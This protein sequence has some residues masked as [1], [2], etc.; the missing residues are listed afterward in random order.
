MTPAPGRVRLCRTGVAS[1]RA[2][3]ADVCRWCENPFSHLFA[4][5]SFP[6]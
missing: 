6:A 1:L 2:N 3:G 4:R 5:E